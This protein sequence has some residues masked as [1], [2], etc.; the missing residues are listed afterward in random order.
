MAGGRG[1]GMVG[2]NHAAGAQ[3]NPMNRDE[4]I[5][6]LRAMAGAV[7]ASRAHVELYDECGVPKST[8]PT[9]NGFARSP[10]AALHGVERRR[11]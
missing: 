10:I 9:G 7:E 2:P 8:I 5:A 3:Q 11:G 6:K 1:K 4:A